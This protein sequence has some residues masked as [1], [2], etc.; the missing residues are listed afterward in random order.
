M[1]PA[2]RRA[3]S[4]AERVVVR[5]GPTRRRALVIAASCHGEQPRLNGPFRAGRQ[6]SIPKT[7]GYAFSASPWAGGTT[8]S[9]STRIAVTRTA[10]AATGLKGRFCQPMLR[11][12]D[13]ERVVHLK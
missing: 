7:Q 8:S 4:E 13:P 6:R 12:F 11:A 10:Q 1:P 3:A 9:R 2:E 5:L